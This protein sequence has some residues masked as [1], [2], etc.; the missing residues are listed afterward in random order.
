MGHQPRPRQA[1]RNGLVGLVGQFDLRLAVTLDA[2]LGAGLTGIFVADVLENLETGRVVFELL[3]D[4][5]AECGSAPSRS[6]GSVS[7]PA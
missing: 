6:T 2:P 7:L 1:L 3:G 4:L 5:L